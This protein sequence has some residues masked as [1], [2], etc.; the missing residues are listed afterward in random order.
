MIG[1]TSNIM[2]S[3][4]VSVVNK[5]RHD[6]VKGC[7]EVG[8]HSNTF[9]SHAVYVKLV[10]YSQIKEIPFHESYCKTCRTSAGGN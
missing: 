8:D 2:I 7:L 10:E 9:L 6:S 3:S 4:I 1:I 5:A